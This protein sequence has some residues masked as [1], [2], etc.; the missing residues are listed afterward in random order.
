MRIESATFDITLPAANERHAQSARELERFLAAYLDGL[1]SPI[2]VEARALRIGGFGGRRSD[3]FGFFRLDESG[4]LALWDGV[5][6]LISLPEKDQPEGIYI[7]LNPVK[8]DLLA[9]AANRLKPTAAK[10][11]AT[12][13]DITGRRM[14]VVDVDPIRPSGVSA[15]NPEKS[16][17]WE[18][19][20]AVIEDLASRGWPSPMIVDSGNGFHAWYRIDL[21]ANDGDQVRHCL[22]ALA[23]KHDTP[24]AKVDTTVFNPSRIVKLPGTWARKGDQVGER[25]HRMARVLRVPQS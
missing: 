6:K 2:V 16:S 7:T 8:E 22:Q 15:S 17:A 21:P 4:V 14:I 1:E 5:K 12:D 18:V 13:A 23:A 19:L 24:E 9:R 10:S 11:S 25:V 20:D 3:E